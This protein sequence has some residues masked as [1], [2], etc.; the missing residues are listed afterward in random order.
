MRLSLSLSC[1]MLNAILT[2]V[3]AQKSNEEAQQ[4][5]V[6]L[7]FSLFQFNGYYFS[8]RLSLNCFSVAAA[9]LRKKK[10]LLLPVNVSFFIFH[11]SFGLVNH[12]HIRKN[13]CYLVICDCDVIH[14]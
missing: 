14:I 13:E 4:P 9:S 5:R 7:I 2:I 12:F 8:F 10:I 6:I 1:I 11:R 3:Y